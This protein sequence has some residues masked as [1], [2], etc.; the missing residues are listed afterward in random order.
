G[1][2]PV[3]VCD[4]ADPVATAAASVVTKSRNAG[5]VCVAPTRFFV[6]EKHYETFA[7]SFAEGAAKLKIGDGMD[8]STQLGPLANVRR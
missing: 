8:P 5:Q 1:H 6:Q 7:K 4:D 2:G 3:I